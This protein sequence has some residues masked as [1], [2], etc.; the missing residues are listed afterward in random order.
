[1]TDFHPLR[2]LSDGGSVSWQRL[3][4]VAEDRAK[5]LSPAAMPSLDHATMKDFGEVYEP[6]DDTYLLIDG[7]QLDVEE[8]EL[9]AKSARNIMELGSGSGVPI[10]F[11][12]TLMKS[13]HA[14]AT[15]I[16]PKALSLTRKTAKANGLQ[17]LETV[18]S[19]LASPLLGRCQGLMDVIIFNPPY[20]PTPDSEVSG[21]G[22]E[23]SWAGGEKGRRVTDRAIPQIAQLLSKSGVCYMITVDDNEP[24]DLA[25]IF[26]NL[27]L[28][29]APLVRRRAFNEYLTVQKIT[30]NMKAIR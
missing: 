20:V 11:C 22:I 25:R 17:L 19:D 26:A 21:N 3:N 2:S 18:Q 9:M 8:N 10:T 12:S 24:E 23:A 30:H 15:D 28:T 13:A 4:E 14:I 5:K 1:M 16:N 29:M 7:I 6:S 27:G